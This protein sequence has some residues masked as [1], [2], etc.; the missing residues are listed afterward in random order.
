[1]SGDGLNLTATIIT[2]YGGLTKEEVELF[3]A[4]DVDLDDWDLIIAIEDPD[5]KLLEEETIAGWQGEPETSYYPHDYEL[6]KM[7][8]GCCNNTWYPRINFRGKVC[9]V[10]VAYHA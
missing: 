9:T 5:C 1:M 7:L 3:W 2:G 6:S 8:Q 4:Q 10:G